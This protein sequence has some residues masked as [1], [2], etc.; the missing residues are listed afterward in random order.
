MSEPIQPDKDF[1]VG[2]YFGSV[3]APPPAFSEVRTEVPPEVSQYS[4]DESEPPLSR[5]VRMILEG[6]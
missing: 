2:A 3:V 1:L 6:C 4:T 5:L